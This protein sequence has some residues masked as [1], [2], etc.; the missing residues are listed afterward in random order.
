MKF[1]DI[2][3]SEEYN[4]VGK[5]IGR[6]GNEAKIDLIDNKDRDIMY[7]ALNQCR[8][9]TEEEI[10]ACFDDRNFNDNFEPLNLIL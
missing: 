5:L 1:G 7:C 6:V 8:L 9:A 3:Y 2:V 4:Q 10:E